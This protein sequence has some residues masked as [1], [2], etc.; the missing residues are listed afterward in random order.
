MEPGLCATTSVVAAGIRYAT[1]DY[2]LAYAITFLTNE[3]VMVASDDLVRIQEYQR[4]FEAHRD[5][6]VR[7]SRRPCAG[8]RLV[9]RSIYLCRP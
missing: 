5:E 3:R 8:G 2:W 9:M 1:S 7:V 6:A 4:A